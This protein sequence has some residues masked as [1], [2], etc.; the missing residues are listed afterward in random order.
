MC[1]WLPGA[2]H[3]TLHAFDT[4]DCDVTEPQC[5]TREVVEASERRSTLEFF[6]L[7]ICELK[8]FSLPFFT[9]SRLL[10]V[11]QVDSFPKGSDIFDTECVVSDPL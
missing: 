6:F 7:L 5:G 3:W 4:E 8:F 1:G 9:S 2:G 10:K 11:F